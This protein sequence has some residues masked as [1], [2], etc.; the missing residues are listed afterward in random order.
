MF[1]SEQMVT[2]WWVMPDCWHQRRKMAGNVC[3]IALA[4]VCAR[5]ELCLAALV[6]ACLILNFVL[7]YLLDARRHFK[8]L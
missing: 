6:A 8:A 2:G 4:R 1:L 5:A 3:E 7:L